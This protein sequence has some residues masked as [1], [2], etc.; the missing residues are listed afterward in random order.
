MTYFITHIGYVLVAGLFMAVLGLVMVAA[1]RASQRENERHG[2]D[3]AWDKSELACAGCKFFQVCGGMAAMR[4]ENFQE[5][6]SADGSACGLNQAQLDEMT[7]KVKKAVAA[8][9][10]TPATA[11]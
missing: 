6:A 3:P 2:Y 1:A 4:P 10:E 9:E 11:E 7:Q 8:A 5:E